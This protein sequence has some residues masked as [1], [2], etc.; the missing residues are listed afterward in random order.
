MNK[1][2][3]IVLVSAVFHLFLKKGLGVDKA[4]SVRP[5]LDQQ[6]M[7]YSL[8]GNHRDGEATVGAEQGRGQFSCSQNHH[9]A[10]KR[11]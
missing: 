4:A 6:E 3:E 9:L 1:M 5:A 10:A 11:P 8:C 2:V 7:E